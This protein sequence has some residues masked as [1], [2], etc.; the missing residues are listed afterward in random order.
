VRLYGEGQHDATSEV[1]VDGQPQARVCSKLFD[2]REFGYLK[3]TVDRPLKL[4]FMATAERVARLPDQSGFAALATSKKKDDKAYQAEVQAGTVVQQC[5]LKAL[6]GMDASVR[7]TSRPVFEKALAVVFKQAKLEL[8][9]ALK[10]AILAALGERDPE[11]EV[12]RDA[13]GHIEPDPELRDTELV[14]LP[15]DIT[16]PLPLGYD[17]ETAHDALLTLV[18]PHCEAY[19]KAEVLPH[20]PDAWIDHSKTKLGYEIPLNR[21]FYVYEPPRPLDV[22]QAEITDLEK[23][24]MVMLSG[25]V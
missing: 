16:L 1:L 14:P 10:K 3:I 7:Y 4:N 11:A 18:K 17:N 12:C 15:K 21:H 9:A 5:I 8:P 24:I 20:V 6:A 25:V 23:E 2:N 13:K 19:L 22:I